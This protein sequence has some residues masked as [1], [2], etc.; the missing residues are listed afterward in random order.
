MGEGLIEALESVRL[1]SNSLASE[2]D[3]IDSI[4]DRQLPPKRFKQDPEELKRDL[5]QNYLTPPT[6]F[7]TAWLNKLQQ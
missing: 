2:D 7:S 6:S 1:Y 5:E 3:Q 4:L